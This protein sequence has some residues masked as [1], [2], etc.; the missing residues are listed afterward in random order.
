[1]LSTEV[2]LSVEV[3][4]FKEA[5]IL[6]FHLPR[7]QTLGLGLVLLLALAFPLQALPLDY[8][9]FWITHLI[10]L[11]SPLNVFIKF[12]KKWVKKYLAHTEE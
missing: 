5:Q 4:L 3:E 6:H 11:P 9:V 2:E 1:M 7:A 10:I 12:G 8:L